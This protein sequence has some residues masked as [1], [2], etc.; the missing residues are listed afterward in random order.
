[1]RVWRHSVRADD[2]PLLIRFALSGLLNGT[3]YA[4]AFFLVTHFFHLPTYAA[5]IVGYLAGLAVGF[6]LH[7]N[8]TFIASG[9][10]T[11][12]LAKYLIAQGAV[13]SVISG[14]SYIASAVLQWP[15][16][17]VIGLG[18]AAAP[19][20]TF[21]LLNCWVFTHKAGIPA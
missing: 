5:A 2:V 4:V 3:V 20:L 13:M 8:F 21:V 6:V 16:Y 12:Q 10:W 17:G 15:T 19:V 1:M 18:I 9:A 11:W 7:R 14:L